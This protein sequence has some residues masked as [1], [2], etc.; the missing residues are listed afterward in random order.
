V[1]YL[2]NQIRERSFF[3]ASES[4]LSVCSVMLDPR[5]T[6]DTAS[7]DNR[8]QKSTSSNY[9]YYEFINSCGFETFLF[10]VFRNFLTTR[11][12]LWHLFD[13][14]IVILFIRRLCALL[15]FWWLRRN[16]ILVLYWCN[17]IAKMWIEKYVIL[18]IWK[19]ISSINNMIVNN[20]L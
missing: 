9:R 3:C 12:Y 18:L 5:R 7:I 8:C 10:G 17:L 4:A 15:Q 6:C 13:T 1:R 16:T 14:Y 11:N 19:L 20:F 2:F